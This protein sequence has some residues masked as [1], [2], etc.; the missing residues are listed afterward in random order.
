MGCK[1]TLLHPAKNASVTELL[2]TYEFLDVY[3]C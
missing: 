2:L 1:Y 3:G